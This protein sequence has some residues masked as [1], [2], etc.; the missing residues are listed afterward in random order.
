MRN[1]YFYRLKPPL[2]LKTPLE[3]KVYELN[4]TDHRNRQRNL[5]KRSLIGN[6]AY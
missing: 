2:I 6:S 5:M 4:C 1:Q 3:N